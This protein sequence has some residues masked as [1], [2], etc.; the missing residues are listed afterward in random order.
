MAVSS[1]VTMATAHTTYS[2]SMNVAPRISSFDQK[3]AKGK[4]P[5]RERAPMSMV[6]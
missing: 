2:P 4:M 3:P 5:T 1:T 6:Q